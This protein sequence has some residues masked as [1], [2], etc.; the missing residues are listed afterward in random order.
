[1]TSW[2]RERDVIGL[3]RGVHVRIR[4]DKTKVRDISYLDTEIRAYAVLGR[5]IEQVLA[6]QTRTIQLGGEKKMK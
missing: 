2:K 3:R 4:R 6:E 5:A 1:M